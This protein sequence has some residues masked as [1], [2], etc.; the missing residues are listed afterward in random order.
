MAYHTV[1]FVTV[2]LKQLAS[3][4]LLLRMSRCSYRAAMR[5][6]RTIS[7]EDRL[8]QSHHTK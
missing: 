1:G 7:M 8:N 6:K 5:T 4:M 2:R 3:V